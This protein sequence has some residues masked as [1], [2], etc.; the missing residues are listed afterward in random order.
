MKTED[1]F[2]ALTDIDDKF[3]AAADT[4]VWNEDQ[5]TV[6]HPAPKRPIWKTL[7]PIA[8]C[9][10]VLCTAGVFG[11]RY[12]KNSVDSETSGNTSK[13]G[14]N[15]QGQSSMD[16][17]NSVPITEDP[18]FKEIRL[19]V[20]GTK[21]ES[22]EFT[23][24]EFP[25]YTFAATNTGVLL[26]GYYM[27][28]VD[29]QI[30]SADHMEN[31]FLVDLNG[32]GKR[33]L[34]ATVKN[35]G[36]KR[37]VVLDFENGEK[38][39]LKS[40]QSTG[41]CLDVEDDRLIMRENLFND[42]ENLVAFGPA[43][44]SLMTRVIASG[45]DLV[46]VD[47]NH[48]FA[49]DKYRFLMEDFPY[50]EF[51][52]KDG[53]VYVGDSSSNKMFRQVMYGEDIYLYDLNGDGKY[54]ICTWGGMGSGIEKS[55]ISV[56]DIAND[57]NY[58]YE[59]DI[60]TVAH[61]EFVD[62][63]LLLVEGTAQNNTTDR[64]PLTFDRMQK[65]KKPDYEKVPF[66]FE[67]SFTL[68]DFE[69]FEFRVDVSNDIRPYLGFEFRWD[70]GSVGNGGV[71]SVY[72]CDLDGDGRREIAMNV[73][74]IGLGGIYVYGFMDN[75]E[76]GRAEYYEE[77]GCRL[78]EL[79]GELAYQMLG[80][81]PIKFEYSK[82]DLKPNFEQGYSHEVLSWDHTMDYSRIFPWSSKY[83]CSIA[84]RVLKIIKGGDKI[85]DSGIKLNDLYTIIDTENEYLYF[86]FTDL[87]ETTVGVVRLT[88]KTLDCI[89]L[90]EGVTVE[91][92]AEALMFVS[93]DGS[94][95]TDLLSYLNSSEVT[96]E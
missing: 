36:E 58:Y 96:W 73:P 35:G 75:G 78:V 95:N 28:G 29:M 71:D 8:A 86:V 32:D 85:F 34:C 43:S 62:N 65:Q 84:D 18:E 21:Y 5:P 89:Y 37:A 68:P 23:M 74:Y 53:A 6:V 33:E 31:L 45:N 52:I 22:T 49:D 69:G 42:G 55:Y 44:L 82:S 88:A 64:R 87:D 67:Q 61:L 94:I 19:P 12:I 81:D 79:N 76:I 17:Q 72:F 39:M 1:I 48:S 54:E 51:I 59:P 7:V 27:N 77:G 26:N 47:N 57:E 3:I 13:S 91:P 60:D 15:M 14:D 20:I 80:N 83:V 9:M 46:R 63:E 30:I 24:E 25:D 66:A 4:N 92:T 70:G 56:Y 2:E 93:Y 90:G 10:A 41:S 50:Q 11:A 40:Y 16:I 38:Y